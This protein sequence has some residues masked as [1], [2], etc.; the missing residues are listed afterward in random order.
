MA[1]DVLYDQCNRFFLDEFLKF[2][3]EVGWQIA[4]LKIL[5]IQ[6]MKN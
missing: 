6:N 3:P 2:A 5:V 4:E 1:A